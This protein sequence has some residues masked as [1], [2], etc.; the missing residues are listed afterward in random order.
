VTKTSYARRFLP[1]VAVASLALTAC[2]SSNPVA[3]AS[4]AFRLNGTAYS[5]ED[6]DALNEALITV[7]QYTAENGTIKR[8]DLAVTLAVLIRYQ[9]YVD[10]IKA[11]GLKETDEDRDA[12]LADANSDPNFATYPE[13]L[14]ETLLKLN[15][16]DRVMERVS[17]PTA[18][19]LEKLYNK[20]PASSGV[21]CLSH[22]LVETEDEAREALRSVTDGTPFAEV[23][24]AKSTEPGAD[25]SGG[26]LKDGDEDCN[27][28][29]GLQ[30]SFDADFMVGAIAA[31]PGV[32]TGPIKTQFGW[33]IILSHAFDDVK[34]SAT[35]VLAQ[36]TGALLL[37]G[38]L[39]A[40]DVSVNSKYGVWNGATGRIS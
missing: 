33:H 36:N 39:A 17:T 24:A 10:F 18:E 31:K 28:L 20:M 6:F 5:I 23:A 19:E 9:G 34:D 3:S 22:I 40:A 7:G 29:P 8:E 16:S 25:Q 26:A 12:V 37:A 1:F 35:R 2:G 38:H 14:R 4:E 27:P 21:L 11:N 30:Q 13:T 32:P 15:V